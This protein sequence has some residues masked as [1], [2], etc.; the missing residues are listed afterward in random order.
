ML[1][2][3]LFAY[4]WLSFPK[5]QLMVWISPD[6]PNKLKRWGRGCWAIGEALEDWEGGSLNCC[7]LWWSWIKS[8]TNKM[9]EIGTHSRAQMEYCEFRI[10]FWG[11]VVTGTKSKFTMWAKETQMTF[12]KIQL[13]NAA[14]RTSCLSHKLLKTWDCIKTKGYSYFYFVYYIQFIHCT[15][16]LHPVQIHGSAE[17]YSHLPLW[18]ARASNL[19]Y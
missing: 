17:P 19:L 4:I 3:A 7:F 18:E 13:R 14:E 11:A 10:R 16:Q 12:K 6:I 1:I 5:A 8:R 9:N 15:L 2:R